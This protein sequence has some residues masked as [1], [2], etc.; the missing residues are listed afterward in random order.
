MARRKA[1]EREQ[2][3]RVPTNGIIPLVDD[4]GILIRCRTS[5]YLGPRRYP[6]GTYVATKY[7][8]AIVL[9]FRDEDDMYVVRMV[10]NAVAYFHADSIVR[11]IKC[12]VG[13]RV[14]TKWG[15]SSSSP[16]LIYATCNARHGDH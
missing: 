4:D 13:D 14:K 3:M 10:Y 7:G 8:T 9:Q 5:E 15:L 16:P 2:T 12:M 6:E 11:E 1:W